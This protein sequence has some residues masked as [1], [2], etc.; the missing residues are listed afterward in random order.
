MRHNRNDQVFQLSLTEIALILVFLLMLLLGWLTKAAQKDAEKA[1]ENL[2]LACYQLAVALDGFEKKLTTTSPSGAELVY[3]AKDSV[4]VTTRQQYKIDEV[5]VK[6]KIE[7]IA[8]GMGAESF[9]ARFNSMCEN[10]VV[11]AC[12]PIQSQGRTVIE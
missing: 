1:K 3:L 12:C 2:Q 7:E 9:Q 11:K 8:E 10:C 5:E 4:K 6:A